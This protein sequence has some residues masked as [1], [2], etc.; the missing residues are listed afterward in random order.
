MAVSGV[1]AMPDGHRGRR[2][3]MGLAGLVLAAGL[4]SGGCEGMTSGQK[5]ATIGAAAGTGIA[6]VSGAGL[7]TT[8]GAG[9]IGGAAGYLGGELVK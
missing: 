6:I 7:A 2:L 5:G 1:S 4:A 8:L 9:L 3:R